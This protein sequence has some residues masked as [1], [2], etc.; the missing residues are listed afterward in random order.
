MSDTLQLTEA[1]I[2]CPSVTPDDA[3]CMDLVA[4][5]LAPLGFEPE[6][7]NFGE[8]RNLWLRRGV[9]A[10]LFVFLGHT[11]VV[12]P[13][14][15]ESWTSPPFEPV[16]RD[17]KLYGRGAADMKSGVAAMVTALESFVAA[18]P[19]HRGSIA[20]MLTSDEEGDAKDG[21]VKVVETLKAR[22]YQIDWCLI[23][24][25]SSF[26]NLGDVIRVGRRGSLN[27][28][29][30]VFGVQGHVAYPEK[31]ENPIH[32]F[33]PALA[34]L[35]AEVW[36]QGNEFF[37]PTSF[38][39]SNLNSGTGAENVVPG[40]LDALFNFRFS[41]A[42]TEDEIKRRVH[43]ILDKHGLRYELSWR[44]SGAPFLTTGTELV[45]AV[46]QA[47]ESVVGRRARP[48]TGGG[49]SDGRFIAPTGAQVV[50]LGPLNGSIHKVDEHTPVADVD[51]LSRI[52]ERVLVN[53][54]A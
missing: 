53:L 41:T 4:A 39:V 10:P 23:G 48:D 7:L 42:L 36:D 54:L 1:L 6:W 34:E 35:T 32:R 17:G 9:S 50:E 2:R 21:V 52:Y 43:A 14:P 22:G 19:D 51:S 11:D 28:K 26:D 30:R 44:L 15:L 16:I 24:E 45:E 40:R 5:R 8:T 25:P 31:V 49:T 13:G 18:H 46:Q 27:G 47:L 12:P 29:L 38:Q 20:L 33:A 3:G 37:P